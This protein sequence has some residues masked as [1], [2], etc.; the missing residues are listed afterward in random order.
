MSLRAINELVG[1]IP[2]SDRSGEFSWFARTLA[3]HP[4]DLFGAL[5]TAEREHAPQRVVDCLRA[6]VTSGT[7]T[8]PAWAALAQYQTLASGFLASLATASVF[9]AMLQGGGMTRVPLKTR[10]I[11]FGAQ[12]SGSA[13]G[14]GMV[15]PVSQAALSGPVV[16]PQKARVSW[17]Q[18]TNC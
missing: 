12:F 10:I 18:A 13:V 6:A 8:D 1:A 14:E 4:D 15:K 9:D 3:R 17:S 2:A 16:E 7:T 5:S 11:V